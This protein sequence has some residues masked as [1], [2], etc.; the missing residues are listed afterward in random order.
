MGVSVTLDDLDVDTLDRLRVEAGRR[1]IDVGALIKQMIRDELSPV[2]ASQ[3]DQTHHE[4]DS[5]AGTWS[6]QDA[7]EF[8]SATADF[9]RNDEDLWK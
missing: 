6:A 1:G 5:L 7:E 2:A 8:L 3:A 9:R 4:L